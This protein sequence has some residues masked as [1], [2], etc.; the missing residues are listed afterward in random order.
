MAVNGAAAEQMTDSPNTEFTPVADS[1][2]DPQVEHPTDVS[3]TDDIQEYATDDE[4][5]DSHEYSTE[6][7]ERMLREANDFKT[8]GNEYFA[9]GQYDEAIGKYEDALF[10]CPERNTEERAVF[11]SN[12][13]ACQMKQN[14]YTEAKDTCS[15]AIELSPAYSKAIFRR[16]QAGEKIASYSALTEALKDYQSVRE[17]PDIT[18][19]TRKEC[20]KAEQR[21]P[22]MIKDQGEKEKEEMMGKLKD[23]GNTLLGKFGLSTN[24]FQMQKD[25]SSGNY[26]VNFVNK[27]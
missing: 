7:L 22:S 6:E 16:A 5:Y 17:L 11:F 24:N 19:F 3:A 15:K 25:P 10:A 12:I 9:K 8:A 14:K 26:S 1:T 23:L 13:A 20:L 27:N 18:D 21:L 2:Q 4:F